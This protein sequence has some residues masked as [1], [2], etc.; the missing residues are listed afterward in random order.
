MRHL[1]IGAAGHAQEV[2]WSLRAGLGGRAELLFFDDRVPRGPLASGLGPVVGPLDA[3]RAHARPGD[4]LV[5]GVALPRLKAAVV[6]R[7]APSGVPWAT[8]V[9]P[10]ATIGP[11]SEIGEGGYVAAGAIVTVNVRAGRFVTINMHCQAAHDD[12]LGDLATLHP[13]VH[14][15]G[16]VRIGEGAELG[17]GAI[18]L[19]GVAIGPWAV[20]GAACVATRDLPG[21]AT[22]VGA[23][24]RE[25]ER[26]VRLR[27]G[28]GG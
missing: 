20:L 9:H 11:G 2:A 3:V 27:H 18:V 10:G 24:A 22:Y 28:T 7:L 19:P 17:T 15:A 23:P 5:L 26:R 21:T 12:E 25:L 13:D 16:G 4:R 8:V 14:H 1:V 6:A